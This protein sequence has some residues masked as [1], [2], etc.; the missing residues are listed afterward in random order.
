[1]RPLAAVAVGAAERP[2]LP[3]A[4]GVVGEM[5]WVALKADWR[6]L[7]PYHSV[8]SLAMDATLI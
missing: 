3:Q 6:G 4:Y 8:S 2:A 1:M 5:R 7:Q